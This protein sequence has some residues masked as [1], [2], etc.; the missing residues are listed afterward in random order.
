MSVKRPE[1]LESK[2]NYIKLLKEK[3][4]LEGPHFYFGEGEESRYQNLSKHL[5]KAEDKFRGH[6][7]EVSVIFISPKRYT[8][9]RME[10]KKNLYI[11]TLAKRIKQGVFAYS[12][13]SIIS[14][15]R[16]MP[17]NEIWFFSDNFLGYKI[18]FS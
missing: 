16:A 18:K 17:D 5:Q 9:L 6:G 14:V 11:E 10:A 3:I 12:G 2:I 8:L 7:S 4:D 1:C 15:K 13:K